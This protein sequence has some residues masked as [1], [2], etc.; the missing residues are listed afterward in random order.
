MFYYLEGKHKNINFTI[1]D[2]RLRLIEFN[3]KLI[4]KYNKD[5]PK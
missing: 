2:K 1:G 5:H 3:S 4:E